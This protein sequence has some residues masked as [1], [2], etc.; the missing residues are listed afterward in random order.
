[1]GG[2]ILLILILTFPQ[3]RTTMTTKLSEFQNQIF[4]SYND[5]VGEIIRQNFYSFLNK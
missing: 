5:Q 4:D 1:M 2:G 3:I